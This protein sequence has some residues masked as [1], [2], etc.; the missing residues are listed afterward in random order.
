M[1]K[2]GIYTRILTIMGI[3][4]AILLLLMITLYFIRSSQ[5]RVLKTTSQAEFQHEVESIFDIKTSA[6]T[7]VTNDYTFW[8][9]F[10]QKIY[11]GD[12]V[13]F[14][15]NI[16]TMLKSF[17]FDYVCVYDSNYKLI[18]EASGADFHFKEILD[19]KTLEMAFVKR[20]LEF[21]QTTDEGFVQISTAT[22]HR[23]TDPTHLL[24][25]PNGLLVVGKCWD[26]NFV[27]EFG[28]V[29]SAEAQLFD[30]T[31]YVNDTNYYQLKA[32]VQ[33]TAPDGN[34][35]GQIV[36]TREAA[37][38]KAIH[39][40]SII[41]ALVLFFVLGIGGLTLFITTQKW[42]KK[43]L[44]L[45]KDILSTQDKGQIEALR[46]N[47]GEFDDLGVLIGDFL[48]QKEELRLEKLR[49]ETDYQNYIQER[50]LADKEIMALNE[51]LDNLVKQ[52]TAE[53]ESANKEL[54]TFSYSV[55]HD[56]K[57]PLR[58]IKGFIQLFHESHK[59]H[60]QE[61]EMDY[62]NK[63]SLAALEMDKLID[64]L[65]TFSRLNMTE[66]RKTRILTT[67][68]VQHVIRYFEPETENR[69]IDFLIDEL[70]DI[71]GD[72]DMMRQVWTNLI[73]NAIKYT[74]KKEQAIIEIGSSIEKNEITFFV[75]DNGAGFN[76]KY[77]DK[78]F[79][80][81]QRMHKVRDFEGIGIGLANVNRIVKRHG[82]R[83]FAHG[84]P[85]NGAT[86]WFTIPV[87][88][89]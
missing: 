89:G 67:N 62:L 75:H 29:C 87:I 24:T 22:I 3:M 6:I 35:I 20:F 70:P 78:L 31:N 58:H 74:G 40:F 64:A 55:S 88:N 85:E 49:S 37:M 25:R 66:M 65:L 68:M 52:R 1:R 34:S 44:T 8:D 43:P 84:E 79:N 18:H 56:L 42:I 9:E 86:F 57:T 54:E 81:F 39:R 53:L 13:W 71:Y 48:K 11:S 5:E 27:R 45:L 2:I 41:I 82:G 19:R 23:E 14:A 72:E 16:T 7:Q 61:N 73:S 17:H 33:F 28:K 21:S 26:A 12:S 63:I 10:V 59:G 80:V 30:H 60:L 47:G 32:I 69:K 77:A 15:N 51:N 76:M 4:G 38:L 36:L 46:R 83:C 50:N